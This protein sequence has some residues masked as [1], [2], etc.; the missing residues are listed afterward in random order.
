ML[1]RLVRI[2]WRAAQHSCGARR[3]ESRIVSL[4]SSPILRNSAVVFSAWSSLSD[5]CRVTN[6]ARGRSDE[7]D[8]KLAGKL[9]VVVGVAATMALVH[10]D[11][12]ADGKIEWASLV[13]GWEGEKIEWGLCV[14]KPTK[15]A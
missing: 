1:E 12:S 3:Y 11:A 5:R 9:L 14:D 7:D 8:M 6:E 10:G 13:L 2:S 4:A 15:A